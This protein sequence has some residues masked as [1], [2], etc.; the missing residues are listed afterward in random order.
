MMQRQ[1][2]SVDLTLLFMMTK[3]Y[4]PIRRASNNVYVFV[5]LGVVGHCT[6]NR[7]TRKLKFAEQLFC[8]C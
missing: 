7:W 2:D 5:S 6:I 3:Q 1:M 4:W 8:P